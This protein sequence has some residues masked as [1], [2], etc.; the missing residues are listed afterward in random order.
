VHASE[1]VTGTL[2]GVDTIKSYGNKETSNFK[3]LTHSC[4]MKE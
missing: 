2:A 3:C 4:D 1:V